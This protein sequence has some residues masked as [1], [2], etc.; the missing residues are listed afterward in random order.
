MNP[1]FKTQDLRAG[2]VLLMKGIGQVS[3]LIAW[4]GDSIFSH[5]AIMVSDTHFVEA[6][7]P[8]SREV[9]ISDRLQQGD[10]YD[11][12]EAYRPCD[13]QG[14]PLDDKQRQAI[15]AA[16]QHYLDVAYPMDALLQLALFASLRNRIPAD[17][18]LRWLLREIIDHI[19]SFDPKHMVCSELVYAAM[20]K[21]KVPPCVIIGAQLDQPFPHIDVVEL[22]KEWLEDTKRTSQTGTLASDTKQSVDEADLK[23]SFERLRQ[24]RATPARAMTPIPVPSPNPADVMPV[25][26]ETSPQLRR[27]GRLDLRTA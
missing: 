13:S 21:A 19:M 3:D 18:R 20:D 4:F 12:V 8:T 10:Y 22:I 15:S 17:D 25:D 2:D 5:A 16:A 23:H 9:A 6:A 1:Y 7:A 11:F 26:L 14:M 27:L 24:H